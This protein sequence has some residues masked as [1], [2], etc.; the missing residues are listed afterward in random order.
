[1]RSGF[2]DLRQA[3][4]DAGARAVVRAHAANVT[5]IEIDDPGAFVDVDTSAEYDALV[6]HTAG[7]SETPER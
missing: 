4:Q 5:D 3:P 6:E 2:N 1:M 7:S